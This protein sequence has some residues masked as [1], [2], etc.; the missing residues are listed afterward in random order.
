MTIR[1][2]GDRRP[3]IDPGRYPALA[4][5]VGATLARWPAHGAFLARRFE[6]DAEELAAA[7]QVAGLIARIAGD[8]LGQ[9]IDGYRQ[10]CRMMLWE[11]VQFRRTGRYRLASFAE[12]VAAVYARPEV[13]DPYLDGLLLSQL[14]WRN[15]CEALRL[16][17]SRFLPAL[18]ADARLREIGP[19]HGLFL[20]VAAAAVPGLALSAWDVS[21]QSLLQTEACLGRLGLSGRVALLERDLMAGGGPPVDAL[22]ASELVEHLDDPAAALA[23]LAGMLAPDGRA[24]LNIPVNSP[25]P[26]HISLFRTPEEVVALVGQAGFFVEEAH[27]LPATAC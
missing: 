22:V 16:Y 21:P 25:A 13:M 24:F 27:A 2:P 14:I 17:G 9:V 15:H 3:S 5:L 1:Q 4:G 11:E 8:R 19:G 26:D 10:T 6:V 12:A 7:E 20:A 23:R 18:P